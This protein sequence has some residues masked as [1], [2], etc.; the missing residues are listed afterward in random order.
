MGETIL[1]GWE[2][3]IERIQPIGYAYRISQ[4]CDTDGD[5][6]GSLDKVKARDV[7]LIK[8]MKLSE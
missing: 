8:Q 4:D 5:C 6:A 3:K 7:V 1:I 2:Q